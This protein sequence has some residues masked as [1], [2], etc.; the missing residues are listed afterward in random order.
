MKFVADEKSAGVSSNKLFLTNDKKIRRK[1]ILP[2][3][4]KNAC[5]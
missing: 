4:T 1:N 3:L 2:A 5:I